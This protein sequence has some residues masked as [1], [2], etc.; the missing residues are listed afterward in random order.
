[1]PLMRRRNVTAMDH[2]LP[3]DELA[4]PSSPP[5]PARSWLKRL[6]EA[7]LDLAF[8]TRCVGCGQYHTLLCDSCRRSLDYFP[9]TTCHG[10]G[11]A[12]R[13]GVTGLCT[14]CARQTPSLTG[15]FAVA[16]TTGPL[17]IAIHRLKYSDQ[18]RLA[19][20]LSLML[21]GW[22]HDNPLPAEVIIPIPLHPRRERER[23]Y[24]QAA[25]LA[26]QLEP[27]IGLPINETI[28]TRTRDTRPQVGLGSAERQQNVAGAFTCVDSILAGRSVLLLDD[29]TT[30]GATLEAA[31]YALRAAGAREVWGL[32]VAHAL[33]QGMG[34]DH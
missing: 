14:R 13:S 3:T 20:P 31:A 9:A 8:P 23:G 19:E 27:A 28:L 26:R 4:S 15:R 16:Y 25:L 10:C 2:L 7:I 29:V 24:N 33:T 21:I 34:S 12:L 11:R 18:S 32:T 6:R 5:A 17:R 1:M 22:W 30:T